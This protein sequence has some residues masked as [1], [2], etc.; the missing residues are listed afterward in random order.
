[1]NIDCDLYIGNKEA[2]TYSWS[3]LVKIGFV[4]RDEYYSL[5]F[6][7]TGMETKKIYKSTRIC[8]RYVSE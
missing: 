3:K 7:S 6:P 4:N 2:P 5:K 8:G 1:V